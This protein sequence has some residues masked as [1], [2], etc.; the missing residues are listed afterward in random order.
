MGI[1]SYK[2]Y[3]STGE[4]FL[5]NYLGMI[6]IP[7]DL[8]P[9]FPADTKT[10]LLT[11]SAK[12]DPQ[13]I[14]KIDE[15]LKGGGNVIVTSGLL[16]ALQDKGFQQI[17]EIHATGNVLRVNAY[18]GAIGAGGGVNLGSTSEILIP[19]IAFMTNDAWPVVRGTANG[20]GAP[21][22]LMEHYSKGILFVLTIPENPSDLYALP[23]PVLTQIKHYLM[24]DFPFQMDAPAKVSLFAYDNK[25]FVVESYLDEPA[26]IHVLIRGSSLH[27]KNLTTGEVVEGKA[28]AMPGSPRADRPPH[29]E[30]KFDVTPHSLVAF[31]EQ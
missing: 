23:Q 1:A 2:P 6:G 21:L 18:W 12:F 16:R 17:A 27:L 31:V 20:R 29:I 4:D 3:Q 5:H 7:I 8:H 19:E 22:L 30:F 15:H 13:I 10:V 14:S 11:E 26:Q 28:Q 24:S 25:S 9:E